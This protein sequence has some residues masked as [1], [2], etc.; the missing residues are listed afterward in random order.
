VSASKILPLGGKASASTIV[1]RRRAR[2]HSQARGIGPKKARYDLRETSAGPN[3]PRKH[4]KLTAEL[5]NPPQTVS[6]KA[7]RG[8]SGER[9]ETR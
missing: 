1:R 4:P 6:P 7:R 8:K 3:G 5:R 9:G 2:R